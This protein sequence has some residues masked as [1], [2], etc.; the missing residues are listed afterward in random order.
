MKR[1]SFAKQ[2]KIT[3]VSVVA[4]MLISSLLILFLPSLTEDA[5]KIIIG[6]SFLIMGIARALG[7]FSNDVYR[8]NF[9]FDFAVGI[10]NI[11]LGILS[12]LLVTGIY[13]TLA[14]GIGIY[15]I[16]DCLLKVQTGI[17]A[18]YFG[19]K[20]WLGILISSAILTLIGVAC[21]ISHQIS[22]SSSRLFMGAAL[23]ADSVQNIWITLYT[24][25]VKDKKNSFII[26]IKL[27]ENEEE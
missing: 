17:D 25:R 13:R 6:V 5:T 10:M 23:F 26:D 22:D 14:T 27:A 8:L 2:A 15:V 7:Y 16:L 4:M 19:L 24:V 12:L 21:V 20:S 11:I 3:Y 1:Y 9:Q 18:K